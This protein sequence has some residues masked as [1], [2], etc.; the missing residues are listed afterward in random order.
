[1]IL[2]MIFIIIIVKIVGENYD[3]CVLLFCIKKF[4][5]YKTLSHI[6]FNMSCFAC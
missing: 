2:I 6:D 1:M 4:S 3:E 5:A